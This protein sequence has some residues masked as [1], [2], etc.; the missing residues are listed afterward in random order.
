MIT[1]DTTESESEV[2]EMFSRDQANT[3]GN[4]V[5]FG[6]L[7]RKLAKLSMTTFIYCSSSLLFYGLPILY[8]EYQNVCPFVRIGSPRPL[9]RV[10]P[11]WNQRVG[12]QHSLAGEGR[13]GSQFGRLERKPGTLS[14]LRFLSPSEHPTAIYCLYG[15]C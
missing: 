11:P 4:M 6:G 2:A 15:D 12:G 8:L 10:C 9:K 7:E 13:G 5:W 14:T 1:F 3:G